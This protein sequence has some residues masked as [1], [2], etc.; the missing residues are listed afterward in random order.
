MKFDRICNNNMKFD[1]IGNND[2]MMIWNL[3]KLIMPKCKD[4]VKFDGI[5][6]EDVKTM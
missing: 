4:N 3:M 2:I 1:G 5:D 6:N